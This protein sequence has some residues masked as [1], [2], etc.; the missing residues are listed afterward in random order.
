[1]CD[2]YAALLRRHGA[3]RR[4]GAAPPRSGRMGYAPLGRG[5]RLPL[6]VKSAAVRVKVALGK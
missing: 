6:A 2:E 3:A 5:S 4:A 1:M